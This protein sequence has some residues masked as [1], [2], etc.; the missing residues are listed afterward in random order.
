MGTKLLVWNIQNFTINKIS[1]ANANP[2]VPLQHPNNI[3]VQKLLYI[4]NNVNLTDP[5]IFV[6]I[7]VISGRGERG[8]PVNGRGAQGLV[9][10]LGHLRAMSPHWC[11]VPALK[12]VNKINVTEIDGDN[13]DEDDNPL[14]QLINDG[15][16]TEGIGVF[17]RQDRVSFQGPYIWPNTPDSPLKVAVPAG[18][19]AVAGP[20]L[21][22]WQNCLPAGN[23]F[24]GQYTYFYP[25]G[26]P[27]EFPA[28]TSRNPFLTRFVEL[29]G[30]HRIINLASVHFPPNLAAAETALARLAGYLFDKVI[31]NN[32]VQV[33]AGDYNIDFG[34]EF[35][36]ARSALQDL[37]R[38]TP[39]LRYG[40]PPS[41]LKRRSIATPTFYQPKL[42]L[43]NVAIR[44]GAQAVVPGQRWA[45]MNRIY[46]PDIPTLM[47]NSLAQ[48]LALPPNQQDE[49]FRR[50]LNFGRLGPVP[51]TSDHLAVFVEF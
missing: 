1:L 22:G 51:G 25:N 33:I 14:L 30:A 7:E 10:L 47:E 17:F 27:V 35:C 21:P 23:Y 6:V 38:F 41:M 19:G 37:Y 11:L 5:D 40:M 46:D 3:N 15:Q 20:Y 49:V 2:H 42:L 44:F 24:A 34:Q 39:V 13:E 12:L 48:I 50:P 32:E 28:T 29:G 9:T 26:S 16:Y 45:I 8:S 43:D 36:Y 4:L 18:G 31:A